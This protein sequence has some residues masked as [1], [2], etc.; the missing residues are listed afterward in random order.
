MSRSASDEQQQRSTHTY[1]NSTLL[2][3]LRPN[4]TAAEAMRREDHEH[5]DPT[6]EQHDT[7]KQNGSENLLSLNLVAP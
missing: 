7:L 4:T 5:Q 3:S 6:E 1:T 2:P